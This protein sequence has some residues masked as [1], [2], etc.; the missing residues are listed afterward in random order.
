MGLHVS[1][2]VELLTPV[3]IAGK[4]S[5]GY[6][7]PNAIVFDTETNGLQPDKHSVLSLTAIK[8]D[9]DGKEL[10]VFDRFYYSKEV[11]TLK[12]KR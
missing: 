6:F 4:N 5:V 10:E 1:L 11:T 12:R 9:P 8:I 7:M 3:L 2:L